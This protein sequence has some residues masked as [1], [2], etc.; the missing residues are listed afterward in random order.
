MFYSLLPTTGNV[1]FI[2][3]FPYVDCL[4]LNVH[5]TLEKVHIISSAAEQ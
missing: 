5:G 3:L 1:L 4:M 2:F